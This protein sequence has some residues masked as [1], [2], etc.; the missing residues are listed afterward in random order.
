VYYKETIFVTD[1]YKHLNYCTGFWPPAI[2][3][4]ISK[5]PRQHSLPPILHSTSENKTGWKVIAGVL[6]YDCNWT[7]PCTFQIR[8]MK[9]QLHMV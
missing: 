7:S 1:N 3:S 5:G 9:F 6:N 2:S 8:W 4:F